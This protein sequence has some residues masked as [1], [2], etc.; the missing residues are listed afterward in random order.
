MIRLILLTDFTEAFAH[1]LLRGILEYSKSREPW[2]VC[3][4]PPSYKHTYGISGVLKWAKKWE[5]DA[6][7]AQFNDDDDVEQFRRQG[8]VA[9][10]QDFKSC[11]SVIPNITSEYKLTGRMAADFFLQKGFKHF[12]FYG[13]EDVVW[14]AERCLGF[15]NRIIEKGYGDNFHEYQ[16]QPLESLWF[17]EP[18]PLV[19]WIKRLPRPVG[20]MACDDTQG[21]K[22][23][24][25][26]RVLGIKIPEEIAVLGVDNDEIICGLS[27]PPLSSVNLNIVK[28]GYEAA[29]LIDRLVQ[30]R[31]MPYEDVIIHPTTIIE[32]ISTDIYA[33]NNPAVLTALKYIH[34]NL[35][36]KINVEDVVRQVP[37]S[38]RLLEIRFRQVVGKSVYQYVLDL[39]MERFSQL[40]LA[41]NEPISDLAMEVGL[42][43]CKN[44]ARQFKLWKGCTPIEYR[45]Q[46][47]V[48]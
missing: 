4:M 29:A 11:F 1:N 8:I 34:Q 41:G 43:D 13:Y 20:L 35:A 32:R 12:A 37:L 6:I 38:R 14:S 5:A 31:N 27:N 15:R 48:K 10:A 18:Q 7:I 44:L 28:G 42:S 2:V 3:R 25:V 19:D 39:R 16:K 24:E 46:N 47:R 26:C 36:N 30:N 9:L 40:L 22:I 33:T 23:I 17:Y 45:M 21:N